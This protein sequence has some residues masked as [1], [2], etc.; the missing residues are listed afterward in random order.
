MD[1]FQHVYIFVYK[2]VWLELMICDE[3]KKVNDFFLSKG[4]H[5]TSFVSL[6]QGHFR[7]GRF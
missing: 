6:L 3:K 4:N 1:G 2:R 7:A 5:M